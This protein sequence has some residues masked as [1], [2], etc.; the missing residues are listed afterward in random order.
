M[1][2]QRKMYYGYTSSILTRPRTY[3]HV[4]EITLVKGLPLLNN[5]RNTMGEN[6]KYKWPSYKSS[7]CGTQL[8]FVSD[9]EINFNLLDK[10][11]V[12]LSIRLR[13][14]TRDGSDF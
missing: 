6:L 5:P 3:S 7:T 4:M 10:I 14:G 13:L 2:Y 11:L 9:Y 12:N 8:P 1:C